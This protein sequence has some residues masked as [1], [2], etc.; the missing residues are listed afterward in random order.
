MAGKIENRRIKII[1]PTDWS[2]EPMDQYNAEGG[3][4]FSV[5]RFGYL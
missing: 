2:F 1:Q 4:A 5:S 3:D